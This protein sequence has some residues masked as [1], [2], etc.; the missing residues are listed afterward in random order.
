MRQIIF[1]LCFSVLFSFT[2]VITQPYEELFVAVDSTE[3][4]IGELINIR[5]QIKGDSLSQIQFA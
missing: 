5:Y 1:L 2:K 4:R 3:L